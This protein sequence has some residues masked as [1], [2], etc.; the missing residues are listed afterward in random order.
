MDMQRKVL[1]P[2]SKLNGQQLAG[3]W[4]PKKASARNASSSMV[5]IPDL[6]VPLPDGTILRGDLYLPST[7][8]SFPLLLAWGTYTMTFQQSGIPLP[9]NEAGDARYFTER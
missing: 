2:V 4:V 3:E 7:T 5:L 6:A 8:G 9:I 1:P